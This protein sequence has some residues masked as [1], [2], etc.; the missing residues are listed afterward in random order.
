MNFIQFANLVQFASIAIYGLIALW[1][2]VPWLKKLGR[3]EALIA[4]SWF[5]IF[6]YTS[7]YIFV[8]QREG[9]PISDLAATQIMVGDLAGAAI[10]LVAIILLRSRVRLGIVFSWLL[11]VETLVDFVVGARQRAIEPRAAPTGVWWLILNFCAPLIL[12]SLPLLIWQLYA[13]RNE[14]LADTQKTQTV[15]FSNQPIEKGIVQ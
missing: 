10:A 6:R 15:P 14:P 4:L 7:P 2:V 5:H 11:V 12:V 8:A 1:Y 9:Y 3:A 13:R